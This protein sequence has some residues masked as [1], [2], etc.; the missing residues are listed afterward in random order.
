MHMP[1]LDATFGSLQQ[2]LTPLR[3]AL[4]IPVCYPLLCRACEV[5]RTK[6]S[7][8]AD[9]ALACLAKTGA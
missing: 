7:E 3:E 4:S 5:G 2:L 1:D 8:L 9:L 6:L